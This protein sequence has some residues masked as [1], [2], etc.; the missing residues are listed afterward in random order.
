LQGAWIL[1]FQL[2]IGRIATTLADEWVVGHNCPLPGGSFKKKQV[3]LRVVQ[4]VDTIL[5]V[6]ALI[7]F[8]RCMKHHLK[9]HQSLFKLLTFKGIVFVEL[10]QSAIFSGLTKAEVFIPTA[11]ISY[12]DVVVGTP[13]FMLCC[14]VFLFSITFIWSFSPSPYRAALSQGVRREGPM[15]KGLIDT[16]N[17]IDILR[18]VGF[19][20]AS[21]RNFSSLPRSTEG[22]QNYQVGGK[23]GV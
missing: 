17:I 13:A 16:L 20:F 6:M 22:H 21:L 5:A 1:I 9:G 15:V 18:G 10:V 4:S 2:I 7:L 11:H 3:I 14:E 12:Q 19:M 8:E 23:T